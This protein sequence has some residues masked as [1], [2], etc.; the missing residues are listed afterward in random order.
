M[1]TSVRNPLFCRGLAAVE[2]VVERK[3]CRQLVSDCCS[4][5]A[6]SAPAGRMDGAGSFPAPHSGIWRTEGEFAPPLAAA[7]ALPSFFQS[8]GTTENTYLPKDRWDGF[9]SRFLSREERHRR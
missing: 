7:A 8:R 3:D 2:S 1:G 4:C 6:H 9:I 5:G